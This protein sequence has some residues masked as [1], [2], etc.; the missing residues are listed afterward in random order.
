MLTCDVTAFWELGQAL[1]QGPLLF[2]LQ[3]LWLSSEMQ[4]QNSVSAVFGPPYHII[5]TILTFCTTNL[6]EFLQT[7]S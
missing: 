2:F 4:N 3:H 1:R 7:F 5:M 6:P